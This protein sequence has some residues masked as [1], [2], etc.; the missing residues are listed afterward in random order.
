MTKR[1]PLYL[2]LIAVLSMAVAC[3]D[4][5]DTDIEQPA[6]TYKSVAV[7]SF[8]LQEDDSVLVNLDSV[9]FSID[10]VE[11]RIFNADSLPKGTPVNALKISV[12]TDLTSNVELIVPRG[13]GVADTTINYLNNPNDTI[14]FSHGPVTLR[15]TSYD[16]SLT[17][18]Y[19]IKVNVHNSIPDTLCWTQMEQ[20]TIPTNLRSFTASKAVK[21]TDKSL[22]F[23]IDK[24]GNGCRA[25][26]A[27]PS[28]A[29]WIK[30]S[31][32]YP[33]DVNLKTMTASGE[34]LYVIA[35]TTLYKSTDAGSTWDN[36]GI[37]MTWIYGT[38]EGDIIGCNATDRKSICYPSGKT[39]TLP[40]DMP[41]K[42]TSS[43][44]SY[45]TKWTEAPYTIFVGGRLADNTLSS[46]TWAW[47][48][49]Q[50][51]RV[52]VQSVMPALEDISLFSYYT[53]NVNT[54]NWSVRRVET[55]YALGGRDKD[56]LTW[57]KL[58]ISSDQGFTWSVA[59]EL[60]QMPESMPDFAAASV[61][62]D[63]TTM[64]DTHTRATAGGREGT[65]WTPVAI[66]PIP[67]WFRVETAPST[68]VSKPVTQW[69]CPYIYLIG[70]I[71]DD[72]RAIDRMWRGVIN[73]LQFIPRY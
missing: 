39:A 11:R 25:S 47:D 35:G 19:Q 68:R 54:A 45:T 7:K 15:I 16:G 70:G 6:S 60:L 62:I 59:G 55:L 27:D 58:Y 31:I 48:G 32:S 69:E 38:S 64:Y 52:D 57:N 46:G 2:L 14:D 50:W 18:D 3:N 30:E 61:I 20:A 56:G 49:S 8:S 40:A 36:T 9:F 37:A 26:S 5:S 21:T 67:A 4:D 10:L 41:I 71:D 29:E 22:I 33:V 17:A 51:A 72:G 43:T 53:Y 12:G 44:V 28:S 13:A 42:N 63:S 34:N 1:S 24:D 66:S 65:F 73:R 23:T